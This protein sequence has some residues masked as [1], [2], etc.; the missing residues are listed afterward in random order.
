MHSNKATQYNIKH[1]RQ[2]KTAQVVPKHSQSDP[3]STPKVQTKLQQNSKTYA[4]NYLRAKMDQDGA[5]MT[6]DGAKM[7]HDGAKL[8]Q[9]AALRDT[10]AKEGHPSWAKTAASLSQDAVLTDRAQQFES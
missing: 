9:D 8:N 5:K 7:E 4:L 10:F 2:K 1:V 6:Q 3:G